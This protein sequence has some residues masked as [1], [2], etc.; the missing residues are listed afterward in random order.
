MTPEY[1][2]FIVAA[3]V[4]VF[5]SA[6]ML[7]S[8]NAVHS[9]LSLVV[10]MFSIA[11]M[12]L[13]LNAPFLAMIQITVYAGAI[14]V[15]FL[16]VIM[17]LG[18]EQTESS[19]VPGPGVGRFKWFFGLATVTG[20]SL[21]VILGL[22]YLNA[23]ID[24]RV[25]P[26]AAPMVRVIHAAPDVTTVDILAGETVLAENVDF[27]GA[28]RFVSVPAG[29]TTISLQPVDGGEA[30]NFALTLEAGTVQSVIAYGEDSPVFAVI[31]TDVQPVSA[32]RSSRV[33]LF[34]AYAELPEISIVDF[35]SELDA[36]DTRTLIGNTAYG[37]ASEPLYF[38][39]NRVNWSVVDASRNDNVLFNM[40]EY[41]I[42]RDTTQI[43]VVTSE[44]QFD[45]TV[46]AGV[47]PISIEAYP[48][49]GSPRAIGYALFTTFVLPFQMLA[50]LLLAAMIGVIVL[51]H[52]ETTREQKVGGRRRVSRPLVNVIAAQVGQDSVTDEAP[53]LPSAAD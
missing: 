12:F 52:R 45:D 34:N 5:F 31:P 46:R 50:L 16:F 48:A 40:R 29:E 43:V 32:D 24:T 9:A 11:F 42:V 14:M 20:L 41:E 51:T 33:V 2:L 10:T 25:L 23:N 47:Y 18:S 26:A 1:V 30:V 8:N 6:L 3:L 19:D 27:G 53:Q 21:F 37:E 13:L 17:L 35:G 38:G 15:L 4:A 7:L 44:R 22:V 28:S 36:N 39:E 49:F